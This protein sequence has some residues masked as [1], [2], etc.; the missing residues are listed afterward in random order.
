[1]LIGEDKSE[2]VLQC[3]GRA[4]YT[5]CNILLCLLLQISSNIVSPTYRSIGLSNPLVRD[6]EQRFQEHLRDFLMSRMVYRLDQRNIQIRHV[7]P[8][9]ARGGVK[10]GG[11]DMFSVRVLSYIHH[12][13]T[14]T[15]EEVSSTDVQVHI[16][17][18]SSIFYI[19]FFFFII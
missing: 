7:I 13:S 15:R 11:P 2:S 16:H 9:M 5:V 14:C 6:T 12:L 4:K 10:S 1:M 3:N 8:T 17:S 19:I 18:Y